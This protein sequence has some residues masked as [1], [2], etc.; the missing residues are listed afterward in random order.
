MSARTWIMNALI[1]QLPSAWQIR[2]DPR[3]QDQISR[4]TV[5]IWPETAERLNGGNL[6][7]WALTAYIMVPDAPPGPR[8]LA[9]ESALETLIDAIE[10]APEI[11]WTRL[12][13]T[14]FMDRFHAYKVDLNI[15]ME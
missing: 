13:R 6:V 3:E 10:A 2:A 12:E 14:V 7:T 8:E 5:V 15:T 11:A 4:T 1:D 9:L